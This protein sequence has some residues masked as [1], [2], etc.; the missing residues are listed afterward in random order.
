MLF[1]LVY[2]RVLC[3]EVDKDCVHCIALL[4]FLFFPHLLFDRT[5]NLQPS[6]INL[7]LFGD[8][9]GEELLR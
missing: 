5:G 3:R 8:L 7:S 9:N 6:F 4:L 1:L 2:T